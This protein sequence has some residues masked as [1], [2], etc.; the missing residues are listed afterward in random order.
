[1]PHTVPH[2][3]Q[4]L[5]SAETSFSQPLKR[6]SSQSSYEPLHAG[7]QAL[8]V[9][10]LVVTWAAAA[11]LQAKAEPQPPQLLALVAVST[12]QPLLRLASQS[13]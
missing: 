10:A 9:Q 12:S 4:L 1:L 7:W 13:L 3:P 8:P 11:V 5:M 2:E 6:L